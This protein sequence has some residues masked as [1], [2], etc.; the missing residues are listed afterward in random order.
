MDSFPCVRAGGGVF[1]LASRAIRTVQSSGWH[2]PSY[3]SCM[4]DSAAKQTCWRS[5]LNRGGEC[6]RQVEQGTTMASLLHVLCYQCYMQHELATSATCSMSLLLKYRPVCE[7][8]GLPQLLNCRKQ[9]EGGI[10]SFMCT[11]M[12]ILLPQLLTYSI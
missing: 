5:L 6:Q 3:R 4:R 11:A 9:V 8:C 2:A 10:L 7:L 1:L 12:V